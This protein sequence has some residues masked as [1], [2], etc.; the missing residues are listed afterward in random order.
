MIQRENLE[1]NSLVSPRP[2]KEEADHFEATLRPQTL[3]EFVG[4]EEIKKN[5]RIFLEAAKKRKE[6]LDHVLL[7]GPAGLGK[8][9]LALILAKETGVSIKIT[10]GPAIE[11]QGDLAAI[12]TNIQENGILFID[13][14]HRLKPIIE[15]VLYTA[16][17]DFGFDIIL[18][19][20]PSARSV[21]LSLPRFTLIGAT[22]KVSLLSSPF[23]DRFGAVF[24]LDFYEASDI[25][26]IILRSA[27]ILQ[28]D[29]DEKAAFRL[30]ESCRHTPRI[31]NRLLRRV[32][33]YVEVHGNKKITLE[34][35][36]AAL[37][38]LRIDELGLDETDRKILRLMV[39]KF[40]GGPVGLNTIS[41][42]LSEEEA[43]IEDIYEPYLLQ[44]GFLERTARGRLVTERAYH[45][46]KYPTGSAALLS[47]GDSLYL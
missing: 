2:F 11:K 21:R 33:D 45:H 34:M 26:K 4:Q 8:T 39:E 36:E 28:C 41:S 19:K 7:H 5:L 24:K 14:I 13:E 47:R 43:T 22:T 29:I 27:R 31:A 37:G 18:G 35:V 6:S 9:S 1:S 16:M 40:K 46:L 3:Q 38:M 12:L 17:E 44:L 30:A 15:E 32:R 42:A 25:Q 20:G 10:S 23:R